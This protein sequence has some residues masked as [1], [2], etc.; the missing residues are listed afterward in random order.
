ML[1]LFGFSRS[2]YGCA[3]LAQG[4]IEIVGESSG[5]ARTC[6][7]NVNNKLVPESTPLGDGD[8]VI[9]SRNILNI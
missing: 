4:V 1:C 2:P 8:F 5:A 7:V 9:L 6:L 3:R